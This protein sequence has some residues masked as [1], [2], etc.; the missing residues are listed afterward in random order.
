MIIPSSPP[1][2][3]L[4]Y[5]FMTSSEHECHVQ[6]DNLLTESK[7]S[8]SNNLLEKSL[9]KVNKISDKKYD[10]QSIHNDGIAHKRSLE[11]WND[12]NMIE[13][14]IRKSKSPSFDMM[15]GNQFGSFYG[16]KSNLYNQIRHEHDNDIRDSAQ[17]KSSHS[18]NSIDY[19][20]EEEEDDDEFVVNFSNENFWHN[21]YNGIK[22]VNN[23]VALTSASSSADIDRND[24][25]SSLFS[26]ILGW[27]A[28]KEINW[29][30]IFL[31]GGGHALSKGF[32][33]FFLRCFI[34]AIYLFV[35]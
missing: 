1:W 23:P 29:E 22:P 9:E 35:A 30:I 2:K 5:V 6:S 32:Q 16:S 34:S 3:W 20:S 24:N 14:T 4:D 31:L 18:K 21:S 19:L 7:I 12:D 8:G 15:K 27:D 25:K 33:V 11:G 10:H 26:P 17:K 28:V 13:T